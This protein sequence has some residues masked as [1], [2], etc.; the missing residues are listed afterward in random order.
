MASIAFGE[1]TPLVDGNVARVLTR[2]FAVE[3][4]PGDRRRERRLWAL[5]AELVAE[6][7]PGDF[8]Q[9]L[10]ELGATVCG[11]ENPSCP[12]CPIRGHCAALAADRVRDLPPPRIRPAKRP[13][14]MAVGVWRR[15]GVVLLG[16]RADRGLFGGLWELPAVEVAENDDLRAIAVAFRS[17]FGPVAVGE[18]LGTVKRTLTHRTLTLDLFEIDGRFVPRRN[19]AIQEWRWVREGETVG[20]GMSTA[21]ERALS[22][23]RDNRS[24]GPRTPRVRRVGG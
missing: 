19:A 9:A 5:A 8:N 6:P 15:D 2:V 3:G 10:M 7:R 24:V 11:A 12:S 18:P 17:L 20:L 21:M 23:A 13:L 22:L 4:T 14:R 16:R 1:A